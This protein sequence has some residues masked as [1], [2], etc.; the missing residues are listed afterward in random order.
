MHDISVKKICRMAGME[1]RRLVSDSRVILLVVELLFAY[2]FITVPL[3]NN[4]KMMGTSINVLEPFIALVNSNLMVLVLPSIFLV[5]MSDFP[6]I[7]GN[8]WFL[9]MRSGKT[10]WLLGQI[11]HGILS[12]VSFMVVHFIGMVLP[13]LPYGFV[14]NVWS[15]ATLDFTRRFPEYAQNSGANGIPPEIYYHMSPYRAVG[16]GALLLGCYLMV[17]IMILLCLYLIGNKKLGILSAAA[18]I[19]MGM[20]LCTTVSMSRFIMPMAHSLLGVHYTKYYHQMIVPLSTSFIY[21]GVLLSA[22]FI[23][24]LWSNKRHDFSNTEIVD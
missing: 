24:C 9:I 1:Y 4:A 2:Q 17:L 20:G 6:R 21:F 22:L 23:V 7:D 10:N 13:V 11:L 15:S 16:M 12:T 3:L 14:G 5:L 8:T 19:A 18:I